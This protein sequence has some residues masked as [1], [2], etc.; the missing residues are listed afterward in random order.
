MSQSSVLLDEAIA[1]FSSLPGI[2][3]KSAMR[4]ALYM[5]EQDGSFTEKFCSKLSNMKGGIK[6]CGKCGFI[7]DTELCLYCS[8]PRRDQTTLCVVEQ[9]PDVIALEDTGQFR[10]LYHVLHG[11]ISPINGKGP[12]SINI[13]SLIDR[14]KNSNI[15]E[16]ILAIS[17]SID[18]DTTAYYIAQELATLDIRITVLS[19]GISVGG[20]LA[21]TDGLTLGRSI[22]TRTAFQS[23]LGS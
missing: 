13:A 5:L 1:A 10:G 8:N 14:C 15:Q 11:I 6:N 3:K 12:D 2:G 7:S 18:G 19:R 21:Y 16:I 20:E 22:T 9:I 23:N 4:L 17:P